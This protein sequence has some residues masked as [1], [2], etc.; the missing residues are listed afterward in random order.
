MRSQEGAAFADVESAVKALEASTG[1]VA[2]G[3]WW[4][5]DD[6]E[7]IVMHVIRVDRP[8]GGGH[9]A[10]ARAWSMSAMM[11]SM[12]SMPTATRTNSGVTPAAR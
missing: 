8:D 6:A 7:Q 9:V 1:G 11:S 5:H 2:G 10:L 12:P 3:L 4:Y